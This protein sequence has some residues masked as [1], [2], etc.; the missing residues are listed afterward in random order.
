MSGDVLFFDGSVIHGSESNTHPTL[1]R[2][3]FIAHYMAASSKEITSWHFP[4]HDF[5][6]NVIAREAAALGGPCGEHY[7]WAN[8]EKFA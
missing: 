7:D 2:R 5:N 3:S 1:W 6:G 8:L 4:L